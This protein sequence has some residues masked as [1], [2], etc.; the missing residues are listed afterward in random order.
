MWTLRKV[1][2]EGEIEKDLCWED[3]ECWGRLNRV[4]VKPRSPLLCLSYSA[5]AFTTRFH[6]VHLKYK[7]SSEDDGEDHELLSAISKSKPPTP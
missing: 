3:N 4:G 5:Q 6:G 7:L 2:R 1:G